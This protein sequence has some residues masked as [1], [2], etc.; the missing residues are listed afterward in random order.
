[1]NANTPANLTG[2]LALY[3]LMALICLPAFAKAQEAFLPVITDSV[4]LKAQAGSYGDRYKQRMKLL[5]SKHRNDYQ[6][7]YNSR[8]EHVQQVF[9]KREI[10]TDKKAMAYMDRL[11]TTILQANPQLD[12]SNIKGY[13]SRSAVPN[14]SYIGEGIFLFNLGLLDKM[15]NE[16]Q[17]AFVI[18]H[19]LAHY[20]L[21]HSENSIRT[22]VETVNSPEMQRELKN[23]KRSEYGRNARL[24]KLA[25]GI[26]FNSRRHSRD[27]EAEADSMAIVLLKRSPFAASE[28][29]TALALLDRIDSSSV[30]MATCLPKTFDAAAYPFKPKWIAKS[31]GL[32]GGHATL[33]RDAAMADSLKTHPDCSQRIKLLAPAV[34]GDTKTS[35]NP[36]DAT[37]FAEL[38]AR[39]GREAV[40]FTWENKQYTNCLYLLL[41]QLQHKPADPYL[42]TQ[43]G[44]VFNAWHAAQRSHTLSRYTDSPSP[45]N[46]PNYNTLAQFVQNLY[47]EDVAAVGYHYLAKFQSQLSQHAPYNETLKESTRILQQ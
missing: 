22:Y 9:D 15:E 27:H 29:L 43:M 13:F 14:A 21:Q 46:D 7:I 18:C 31:S 32:L 16:S 30:D 40:A 36:L 44:Q 2:R 34:N 23:I 1:M 4:Y 41:E 17:V 20:Y 3:L 10:Y 12:A 35:K 5:P 8:W 45:Y 25:K 6:E 37:T 42:V 24:D 47:L 26:R 28:G 19:E 38:R 11:L 39:A 33:K